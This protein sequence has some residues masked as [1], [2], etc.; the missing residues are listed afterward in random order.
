[1]ALAHLCFDNRKLSKQ[2][3]LRLL[4]QI[5]FSD[6]DKV[7]PC[8]EVVNTLLIIKD[9]KEVDLQRMRLE[10]ILGFAFLKWTQKAD[11]KIV[12]GL[13][14]TN[15]HSIKEEIYAM[16]SMLTYDSENDSA[17]LQLLW[18]YHGRM[19]QYTVNCLE[20]L[21]KVMTQD[22]SIRKYLSEQPGPTY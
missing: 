15:C 16:K 18:R 2:I 5:V 13:E 1:M 8:I 17:L 10:W 19:D 14:T 22:E 6:Y 7:K 9:S 3:C 20:D 21:S 4:K 11:F 12:V